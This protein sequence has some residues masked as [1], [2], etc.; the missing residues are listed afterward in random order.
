VRRIPLGLKLGVGAFALVY[1]P[2]YLGQYGPY[3]FLWFCNL[4]NLLLFAGLC[5]ESALLASMVALSVLLIQ[6][7]WSVD[8]LGRLLLEVHVI[9]GTGYMWKSE[10]PL[11]IRALSLFHLVGPALMLF[12][13][14]RL[15]YDRRALAAQTL[16]AWIVLPLCFFFTPPGLDVN[17]VFGLFDRPQ[18]AIA[19][20]LYLALTMLGYVVL[21]YLPTHLLLRR[22]FRAPDRGPEGGAA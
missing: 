9:G 10:I 16:L 17:W 4:G 7:L 5:L 3:A 22:L 2:A 1:V 20:G 19:P 15:G 18:E 13:L 21:L 11:W 14:R 6:V 12:A 8:F